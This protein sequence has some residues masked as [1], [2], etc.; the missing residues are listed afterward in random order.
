[1]LNKALPEVR[2]ALLQTFLT[3]EQAKALITDVKI[4]KDA[5]T[6]YEEVTVTLAK[7]QASEQDHILL[8]ITSSPT[9][10][11]WILWQVYL[12][13]HEVPGQAGIV[14]LGSRG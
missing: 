12:D 8:S 2:D 13:G 7:P 10:R 4:K 14:E 6:N 9:G 3:D 1:M 5:E 11:Y